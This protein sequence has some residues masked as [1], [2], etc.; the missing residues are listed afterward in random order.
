MEPGATKEQPDA[1]ELFNMQTHKCPVTINVRG[2]EEGTL[3]ARTC[4]FSPR[5]HPGS[6]LDC[7]TSS[8]PEASFVAPWTTPEAVTCYQWL[9]RSQIWGSAWNLKPGTRCFKTLLNSAGWRRGPQE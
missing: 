5:T 8:C 1:C 4:F 9:R 2:A 3:A 6:S 7:P